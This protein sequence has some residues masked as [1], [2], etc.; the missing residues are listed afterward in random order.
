MVIWEAQ[1]RGERAERAGG[2]DHPRS[3]TG[4]ARSPW[5]EAYGSIL[6]P[7]ISL[8]LLSLPA[9][10]HVVIRCCVRRGSAGDSPTPEGS[11]GSLSQRYQRGVTFGHSGGAITSDGSALASPTPDCEDSDFST[12]FLHHHRCLGQGEF[13]KHFFL[14]PLDYRPSLG[15]YYRDLKSDNVLRF[16][17]SLS[18]AI[19]NFDMATRTGNGKVCKH[20]TQ[21]KSAPFTFYAYFHDPNH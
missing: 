17:G 5:N 9:P 2:S 14:Q 18:L 16:E 11:P 12:K 4:L 3:K 1:A 10:N 7:V 13:V 19:T 20:G 15:T 8:V 21:W 6:Y